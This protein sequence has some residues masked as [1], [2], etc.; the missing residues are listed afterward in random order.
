[1]NRLDTL[2]SNQYY[3]GLNARFEKRA[4]QLRRNGFAYVTL[5]DGVVGFTRRRRGKAQIIPAA[6]LHSADKRLWLDTMA[7]FLD[8]GATLPRPVVGPMS[9]AALCARCGALCPN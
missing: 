6:L 5:T 3:G 1:M 8:R 7:R 4:V 9:Y 2:T